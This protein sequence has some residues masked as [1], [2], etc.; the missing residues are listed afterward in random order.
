MRM[1]TCQSNNTL[2]NGQ[3]KV[4]PPEHSYNT[5]LGPG[6]SKV[7]EAQEKDLKIAFLKL[8]EVLK[9]VN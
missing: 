4:A 7:V 9:N 1:P 6:Y 3:G 2:N 8:I 5:I